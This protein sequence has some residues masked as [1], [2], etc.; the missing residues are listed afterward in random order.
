MKTVK[1]TGLKYIN[2]DRMLE[3]DNVE[4]EWY[5]FGVMPEKTKCVITYK[6]AAFYLES[7]LTLNGKPALEKTIASVLE[8]NA[9]VPNRLPMNIIKIIN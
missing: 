4:F 6:N 9:Q 1:D 8:N 3:G 2:G 5:G 7:E